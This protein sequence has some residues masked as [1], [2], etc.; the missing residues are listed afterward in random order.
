[1]T[2]GHRPVCVC[3]CVF[4]FIYV[5]TFYLFELLAEVTDG[6]DATTGVALETNS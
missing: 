6:P 4:F 5:N 1:M 3:V 2:C